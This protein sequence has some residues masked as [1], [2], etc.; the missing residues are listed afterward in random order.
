VTILTGSETITV[1]ET[2]KWEVAHRVLDVV[3]KLKSGQSVG[4]PK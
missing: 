1:S 3:V 4:R 2:T